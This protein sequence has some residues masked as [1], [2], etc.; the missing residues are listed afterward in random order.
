[1]AKKR[2]LVAHP[3]VSAAGGGNAVAAW[4]LQALRDDFDVTLATLRPV[5]CDALNRSWGTTLRPSDFRLIV[6]PPSYQ[7]LLRCLPTRGA[8][9]EICVT[10]RLA[11]DLDHAGRF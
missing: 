10:M 8:L 11:R 2:V 9:L 7:R 4:T 3:R 5:E 1:M 6:A